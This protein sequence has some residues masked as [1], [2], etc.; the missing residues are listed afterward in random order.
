MGAV[1][2]MVSR[3]GLPDA[4]YMRYLHKITTVALAFFGLIAGFAPS[5]TSGAENPEAKSTPTLI[6]PAD[7][8]KW[9]YLSSG[10]DMSYSTVALPGHHMFDNVF[11]NPEAYDAF[12]K[13][14]TWPD[15]TTLVLEVRESQ[16]KGSIN[17]RGSYQAEVM[18]IEVH[19]RDDARFPGQWGFFEFGDKKTAQMLPQ[20]AQC[21]SCHSAHGAVDT[22]FVQFYPTLLPIATEK[23]TLS[24]AYKT[25]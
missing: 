7:Y 16:E 22:T 13:T 12:V 18:G 3:R 20:T 10:I 9:V 6:Y 14:G 15:K 24:Q 23:G 25:E 11:V 17:R 4:A 1:S 5:A 21:Y 2:G 19:A 8:R